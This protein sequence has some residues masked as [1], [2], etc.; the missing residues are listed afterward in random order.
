MK[1]FLCLGLLTAILLTLPGLTALATESEYIFQGETT[2][3]SVTDHTGMTTTENKVSKWAWTLNLNLDGITGNSGKIAYFRSGGIGGTVDYQID[4]PN[5]GEYRI[6][7]AFRPND[8]SYATVQPL[9][10]G[11]ETAE[12]VSLKSGDSAGGSMNQF[13][14]V[15]EIEL[16]RF[17]LPAGASTVSFR[18]LDNGPGDGSLT[19]DY[20]RV[21]KEG[22]TVPPTT[23]E[24]PPSLLQ[25]EAEDLP[26]RATDSSGKTATVSGDSAWAWTLN[27][28]GAVGVSRQ[29]TYFRS[30]GIGGTVEFDL[31][32]E[33]AAEH[34]VVWAYRPSAKSYSDVQVLVNGKEIGGVI[35]QKSGKLVGGVV[36]NSSETVRTVTLGNALFQAGTNT[37]T[38]RMVGAGAGEQDSAFTVDYIQ[39]GAPVDE[40]KLTFTSDTDFTQIQTK[41]NSTPTT[42]NI[43]DGMLD[44]YPGRKDT[45]KTTDKI[46]V[47]P[48]ADCYAP[49]PR[50][51]LTADGVPVPVTSISDQYDYASFDYDPDK[52]SIELQIDCQETVRSL[53]VSPQ[54]KQTPHSKS[55]KCITL[56][57][58]EPMQYALLI[59]GKYLIISVDPMQTDVPAESGE[60]I[61]NITHAPYSVNSQMSDRQMTEAIQKALDD[62]S[63]YGSVQGHSNGVVYVPAGIYTVGDLVISSNTYLY[64]A[65]GAL[66]RITDDASLLSVDG[67]K[68]SMVDPNGKQGVDYTWW[69]ST[70]FTPVGMEGVQGS[71]DI[72]IGGRGTLDGRDP[73]FWDTSLPGN[74]SIGQNTVVPIA[75]SYF[76]M[77]GLTVREAVC[78]SV[79]AVRSD[80]LTFSHIKLLNRITRHHDENDGIDICECQTVTVTDSIGFAMDDPFSAKTWPFKTGITVNWPGLTEYLADV[81][82]Q[83]CMS[84]TQRMGFKIGQ[85]TN[86]NQYD[87]TF[88]D[89]TVIDATIGFG[90][91]C[92]SGAGVVS[93]VVFDTIYVEKLHSG[94]FYSHTGWMLLHTQNNSRGNGNLKDVTVKNIHIYRG[95]EGNQP[96]RLWGYDR[97][98]GIDGVVFSDIYFAEKRAES[99]EQL[100]PGLDQNQFALHVTM[101]NTPIEEPP[102]TNPPLP[103]EDLPAHSDLPD[104]GDTPDPADPPA[105]PLSLWWILLPAALVVLGSI[106]IFIGLRQRKKTSART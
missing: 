41:E 104:V 19:V 83:R 50:Y 75:C 17:T 72:R 55:G 52:G 43:P 18:L 28:S 85:G 12:P 29:L 81:T 32:V 36:N 87:V 92:S 103:D 88:R 16:G 105:K 3:F 31:T 56:T 34:S 4:L 30:G 89:C 96:I 58:S 20:I 62:A 46:T 49:S 60:G 71:Y 26:I 25:F 57:V 47:Y 68:T 84:Y 8:K 51:T 100:K 45:P 11:A 80:H 66:L 7:W 48:L 77:E 21:V 24:D 13:N 91:H 6:Y 44:R 99:P 53:T 27:L 40:S 22:A 74:H 61:F 39:L 5:A 14:R 67:T 93:G 82:F 9:V 33:K 23:Q 97:N 54:H 94:G 69:I 63:A 76:T 101:E 64:L 42:V 59:N 90:V 78:W 79:V 15:R 37:V 70:A 2:P 86:Q 98:S 73:E 95:A 10:N 35:S 1:K 106:G 38:F 102:A 65:G